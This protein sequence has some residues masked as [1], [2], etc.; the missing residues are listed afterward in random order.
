[1]EKKERGFKSGT[2]CLE[3]EIQNLRA[4]NAEK[5]KISNKVNLN[6]VQKH[7]VKFHLKILTKI[8][9][10]VKFIIKVTTATKSK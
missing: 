1:M 4:G 10:R 5:E 7:M 9:L 3:R 2:L 8:H 6:H